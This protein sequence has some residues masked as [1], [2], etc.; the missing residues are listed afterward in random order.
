MRGDYARAVVLLRPLANDPHGG[1]ATLRDL[2]ARM[3]AEAAKAT[4]KAGR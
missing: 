1:G 3:E 4:G 2:L